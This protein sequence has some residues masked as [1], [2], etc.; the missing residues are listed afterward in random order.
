MSKAEQR[1]ATRER[2][3]DE[4]RRREQEEADVRSKLT[5][6]WVNTTNPAGTSANATENAAAELSSAVS[7]GIQQRLLT[8]DETPMSPDT[9]FRGQRAAFARSKASHLQKIKCER[10]KPVE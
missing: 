9:F 7:E 5:R 8:S 1:R 2:A 3:E 10:S 6:L 4:M